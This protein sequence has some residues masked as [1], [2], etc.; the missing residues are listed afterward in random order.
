[1]PAPFLLAV[2]PSFFVPDR[3]L[4]GEAGRTVSLRQL[5]EEIRDFAMDYRNRN[6]WRKSI[7]WR[8]STHR[9]RRLAAR[10]LPGETAGNESGAT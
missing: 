8:I 10:Y 7:R 9:L 1:M 4:I 5:D 3:E 2:R 6:W